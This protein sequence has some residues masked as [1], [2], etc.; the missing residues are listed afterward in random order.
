L[1]LQ[2]RKF[3][4][5]LALNAEYDKLFAQIEAEQEF[6]LEA[7]VAAYESSTDRV[8]SIDKQLLNLK[9]ERFYAAEI[10]QKS[11][12]V[13]D[14]EL[15]L[16]KGVNLIEN[17]VQQIANLQAKWELEKKDAELQHHAELESLETTLKL[18]LEKKEQLIERIEK[19]ADSLMA[20]LGTHKTGWEQTIGKV[21]DENL[22]FKSGLSPKLLTDAQSLYGL[23]IDLNEIDKSVK[24]IDDYRFELKNIE[25]QISTKQLI[26]RDLRNE[27]DKNLERIQQRNLPK[28]KALKEQRRQTEYANEQHSRTIEKTKLELSALAEKAEADKKLALEHIQQELDKAK[29]AKLDAMGAQDGVKNLIKRKKE[30][31]LREKSKRTN[32]FE[33]EIKDLIDD[34]DSNIL[35]KKDQVSNQIAQLTT[36]RNAELAHKGVDIQRLVEIEKLVFSLEAELQFIENNRHLVSEF[37]KDKRELFDKEKEFKNLVQLEE[38][39]LAGLQ[40]AFDSTMRLLTESLQQCELKIRSINEMRLKFDEDQLEYEQFKLSEAYRACDTFL[41]VE[42]GKESKLSALRIIGEIKEKYYQQKDKELEL[43]IYIDKF[44]G[45]FSE[46]NIFKFPSK[47]NDTPAY[48]AWAQD[49]NDFQEEGKIKQFEKRTNERFASIIGSVGKE[50]TMLISKT[51]DI[52]KIINK[53]NAD[54]KQKNF[55]TAVNNIELDVTESK[56]TAVLLLKK[57]KEFNDENAM[58]LG[59]ANLFSTV[60]HGK[61]N[62]KAVELLKQ[63]IKELAVAKNSVVELSDSFELSFRVEENGNDTGWVEKLSNVGSEGTDVLVKAMINIMLLNVFKEGASRRFKDFKLHCMM[64]EIG[65]LHPTN[66][67]GILKFANDRNILLINGSPTENTPLDYR[68]IYKIHK[69]AQKQSQVKRIISNTTLG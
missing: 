39:K 63:L 69:D 30:A 18:D 45:H 8:H 67:K 7:K 52:K 35:A 42:L 50:T 23:K 28:I 46:H 24:T 32:E 13:S 9:H 15:A 44:L 56:N 47:L 12:A 68:H 65:K 11:R 37:N 49:L 10:A 2:Q 66:V 26:N 29:A 25:E 51:G 3:Q 62:E 41:S 33:R 20:W 40:N 64:D 27:F 36:Q 31:K 61:S 1:Q 16:H 5:E 55:V 53:I 54:F 22:L 38:E 48:I 17:Y 19:S 4:F 21:I 14:L 59:V 60:D 58:S 43:R 6:E 34:L 57:I